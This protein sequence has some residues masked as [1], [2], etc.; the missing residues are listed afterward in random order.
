MQMDDSLPEC[1]QMAVCI[2]C[3]VN[4][5]ADTVRRRACSD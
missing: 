5:S 1:V 4:K 2:Q 3:A